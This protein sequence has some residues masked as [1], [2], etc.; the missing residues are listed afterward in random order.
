MDPASEVAWR[1]STTLGPNGP[2]RERHAFKDLSG[3]LA[4]ALCEH[5]APV[6]RLGADDQSARL[7]PLCWLFFGTDLADQRGESM[8]RGGE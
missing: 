8:W 3:H 4:T 7:C 1:V 6:D 2:G 5:T